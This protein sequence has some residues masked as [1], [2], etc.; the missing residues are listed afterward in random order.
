MPRVFDN[1]DQRLLPIL[2]AELNGQIAHLYSL[3]ET[4]FAHILNT[5]SL[6]TEPVEV[7]ALNAYRD[8]ER[9]LLK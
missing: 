7:A 9:G 4:E 5:F 2:R 6:V 1:I 8:V 3:T